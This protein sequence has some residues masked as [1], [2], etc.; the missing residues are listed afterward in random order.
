MGPVLFLLYIDENY[1]DISST[2]RLYADDALKYLPVDAKNNILFQR[3]LDT[4]SQWAETNQMFINIAKCQSIF[5]SLS[6]VKTVISHTLCVEQARVPFAEDDLP[7]V[8]LE[9]SAEGNTEKRP[10]C[11]SCAL[12]G[13]QMATDRTFVQHILFY[14]SSIES[15]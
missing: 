2:I 7:T 1:A 4:S 15:R 6:P 13:G 9:A 14:C 3:D 5:F 11:G 10:C 8:G 12:P